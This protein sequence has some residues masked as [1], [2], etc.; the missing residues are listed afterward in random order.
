MHSAENINKEKVFEDKNNKSNSKN[1]K[2]TTAKITPA[3]AFLHITNINF[4]CD[5]K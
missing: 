2:K 1:I 3:F 4:M 5:H